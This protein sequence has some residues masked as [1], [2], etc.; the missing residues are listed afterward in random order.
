MAALA[1]H[2][3][4]RDADGVTH[5]FGPPLTSD[6][7]PEWATRQITNPK[8][9][10]D[11]DVPFPV[12]GS[13]AGDGG[14]SDGPPPQSGKGSG[15]TAWRAYAASKGVEL[16]ADVDGRDGVIAYLEAKDVPVE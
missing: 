14:S 2:V 8:V 13:D 1:M 6:E 15:E 5:S 16:P 4:V 9:W 3:A 12:G 10:E 7:L 11:G